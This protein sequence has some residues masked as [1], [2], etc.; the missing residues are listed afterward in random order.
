MNSKKSK[1]LLNKVINFRTTGNLDYMAEFEVNIDKQYLDFISPLKPKSYIDVGGFDGDTAELFI[2][3]IPSLNRIFFFEPNINN[4]KVAKRRLA[5]FKDI[6][7]YNFG[8]GSENTTA[9]ISNADR[10][11]QSMLTLNVKIPFKL[12]LLNWTLWKFHLVI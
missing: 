4:L 1:D 2:E 12:K 7:F 11:Q 3:N 5:K 8:L 6:D 10:L 9:Y